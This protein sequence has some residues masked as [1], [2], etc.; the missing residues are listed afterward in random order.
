[1]C[2]EDEERDSPRNGGRR[3]M[4]TFSVT[5]KRLLRCLRGGLP[6]IGMVSFGP[7]RRRL[8]VEVLGMEPLG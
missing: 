1:M 8:R 4:S 5:M 7:A 2:K 3:S 6:T